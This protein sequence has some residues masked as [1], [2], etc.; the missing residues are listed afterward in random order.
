[1]DCRRISIINDLTVVS[2]PSLSSFASMSYRRMPPNTEGMVSLKVG[3]LTYRTTPDI[4]KRVFE[5]YGDVG[6]VYIPRD[7][8]TQDSRGF[9]FVRY[10]DERDA[11]DAI[12]RLNGSL[13]DGR[14][15]R[16]QLAKHTRPPM[17]SSYSRRAPP[18][19]RRRRRY[20]YTLIFVQI[21]R[22]CYAQ[23]NIGQC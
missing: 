10:Y 7:P 11:D 1:M 20:C 3:N 22:L 15:L 2:A 12:D 19:G 9:A 6:D 14:E 21:Y 16:V 13:L 4:L 8:H 5:K 18:Q 17:S 23:S